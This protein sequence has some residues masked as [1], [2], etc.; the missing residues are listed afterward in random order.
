LTARLKI[1]EVYF[2]TGVWIKGFKISLRGDSG[3]QVALQSNKVNPTESMMMSVARTTG[4]I[5][6]N[7]QRNIFTIISAR[8][9]PRYLIHFTS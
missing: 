7:D 8:L 1:I 3:M 9:K 2:Y 4:P 5:G 6:E